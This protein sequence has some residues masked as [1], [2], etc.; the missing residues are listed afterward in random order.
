MKCPYCGGEVPS[1]ALSCP[2]C[3]RENEEGI[4]F[5]AKVEERIRKNKLLK[6]FLRKQKTP[7]LVQKMMTRIILVVMGVNFFLLAFSFGIFLFSESIG[8]RTI[9]KGSYAE[10]YSS[11]FRAENYYYLRFMEGVDDFLEKELQEDKGPT[12]ED[13]LYLMEKG[14]TALERSTDEEEAVQEEIRSFVYAF[15][16]GYLGMTEEELIFLQPDENGEYE[17]WRN[18][19]TPEMAQIAEDALKRWE[20]ER[21]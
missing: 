15:L 7:E 14:Y 9:R 16:E 17:H 19:H 3:G 4:K 13:V 21:K 20:E 8:N 2:Y 1:Q 11:T 18:F 6:P 10:T 12:A 5:A